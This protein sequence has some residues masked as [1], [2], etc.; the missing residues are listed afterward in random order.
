MTRQII[1]RAIAAGAGAG[2]CGSTGR[3]S[4]AICHGVAGSAK[5]PLK[6]LRL[7][8]G[9]LDLFILVT[10]DQHFKIFLTVT[11]FKFKY[12]HLDPSI[13]T[14]ISAIGGK[15]ISVSVHLIR[16]CGLDNA[17]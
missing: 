1:G 9:A 12:R 7:A 8:L 4:P 15:N 2:C 14:F 10:H 5:D 13:Y 3:G 11:T 6:P 17:C 16:P